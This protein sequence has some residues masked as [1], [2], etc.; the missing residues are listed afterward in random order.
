MEFEL[1]RKKTEIENL[2]QKFK[3]RN[4]EYETMLNES[5]MVNTRLHKK[6]REKVVEAKKIEKQKFHKRLEI[7]LEA[8]KIH[9]SKG[10][11]NNISAIKP[12][13]PP[14]SP[15]FFERI[16]RSFLPSPKSEKKEIGSHR[17]SGFVL[18]NEAQSENESQKQSRK[19]E[20]SSDD[21]IDRQIQE[22]KNPDKKRKQMQEKRDMDNLSS[23]EEYS[24]S[25]SSDIS[26]PKTP[27]KLMQLSKNLAEDQRDST[28]VD[29]HEY[30]NPHKYQFESQVITRK[31]IDSNKNEMNHKSMLQKELLHTTP[32][33]MFETIPVNTPDRICLKKL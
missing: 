1:R 20:Q 19:K 30:E 12:K 3:E 6:K 27:V 9:I 17:V 8:K 28:S 14:K 2:L 5:I 32:P 7:F 10:E 29:D 33:Q 21:E 24:E 4:Q 23:S 22:M 15:T 11:L 31:T 18:N 16:K 26:Q 25:M 13:S